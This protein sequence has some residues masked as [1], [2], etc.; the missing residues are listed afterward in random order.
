ME[1]IC[2]ALVSKGS[3]PKK[4]QVSKHFF[5]KKVFMNWFTRTQFPVI[6]RN[7]LVECST[8]KH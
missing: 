4:S 7:W 1:R 2:L 5:K 3:D 8:S 6:V